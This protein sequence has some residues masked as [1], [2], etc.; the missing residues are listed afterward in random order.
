MPS[1]AHAKKGPRL[2]GGLPCGSRI[3]G[4]FFFV[5]VVILHLD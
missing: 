3:Q 2:F 5:I 1:F 4:N